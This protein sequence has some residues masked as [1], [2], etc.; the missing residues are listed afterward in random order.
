MRK[1]LDF[2]SAEL[3]VSKLHAFVN[4][5]D[6][7]A[8]AALCTEDVIWDD[9]AAARPLKGR[10]AVRRFHGEGMFRA[11][12]DATIERIDGP[13]LSADGE[14]FAVRTRI[15]GTM[16]GPL[17]PPGFAPTGK[18]VAFETAEFSRIRNG[19]LCQHTVVLNM[20]DLARQIGAAP[21]S[22][23]PGERLGVWFQHLAAWRMK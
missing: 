1:P 11:L 16:T 19:L 5:H 15:R 4:A 10:D 7:D 9:P 18:P 8:I 20:L 14:G 2:E 6:A 21:K 23:S 13:Y 3:F 17:S 22:G 12:P